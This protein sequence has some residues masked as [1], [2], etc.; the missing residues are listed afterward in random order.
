M[1]TQILEQIVAGEDLGL[2][3]LTVEQYQQMV[4]S[5]VFVEG[6][7]V[8]LLD[9]LLVLKDRR[10][11]GGQPT[12][13]GPRHIQVALRLFK[14][15]LR[16]VENDQMHVRKEDPFSLPPNSTPEPDVSVVLGHEDDYAANLPG[17]ED[18][19]A[20]MEVADSSLRRDRDT[21]LPVYAN[22]GIK[23]YWIVDLVSN[24]IEVYTQ[25]QPGS[26]QYEK[27]DVFSPGDGISLALP[28]GRIVDVA[29]SDVLP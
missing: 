25:P 24:Q 19:V 26:G 4:A 11:R 8:E 7:K 13:A 12:I 18:I 15:L 29:V 14:L 10:D 23:M 6:P 17:P 22:A 20:V 28:D 16:L 9:G 21:K 2:A 5:G 3:P 1:G 27:T